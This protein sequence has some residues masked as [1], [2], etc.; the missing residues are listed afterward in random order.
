M[1]IPAPFLPAGSNLRTKSCEVRMCDVISN[2]A[3]SSPKL[4]QHEG[5]CLDRGRFGR[6]HDSN[7]GHAK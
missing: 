6:R 3:K 5:R 1:K 7:A 2:C 4:T